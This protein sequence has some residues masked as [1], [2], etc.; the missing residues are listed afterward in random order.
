MRALLQSEVEL[1]AGGMEEIIVTASRINN[2]NA[3][4]APSGVP[5]VNVERE[6]D[7]FLRELLGLPN[8]H[9]SVYPDEVDVIRRTNYGIPPGIEMEVQFKGFDCASCHTPR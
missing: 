2:D 7:F 5:N 9:P 8:G 3:P 6:A 4:G 1:V